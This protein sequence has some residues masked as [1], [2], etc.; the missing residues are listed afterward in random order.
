MNRSRHAIGR[1][2][3]GTCGMVLDRLQDRIRE[4]YRRGRRFSAISMEKYPERP[5][6]YIVFLLSACIQRK[7]SIWPCQPVPG[8]ASRH[9]EDLRD[10]IRQGGHYTYSS[11][12]LGRISQERGGGD[13]HWIIQVDDWI[14]AIPL[15]IH[16]RVVN[17]TMTVGKEEITV[18]VIETEVD[19]EAMEVFFR[20]HAEFWAR[21]IDA[22]MDS[23]HVG[24]ARRLLV[25][26]DARL[27][28]K[29]VAF[30]Q[31]NLD[32]S[33]EDAALAALAP[34]ASLHAGVAALGS[35]LERREGHRQH[36]EEF[37]RLIDVEDLP[38]IEIVE[39]RFLLAN[40]NRLYPA[41]WGNPRQWK[42]AEGAMAKMKAIKPCPPN[43]RG[44]KR[45]SLSP[46][47][48]A[49]PACISLPDT[50]IGGDDRR[51]TFRPGSRRNGVV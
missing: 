51:I 27:G 46:A 29:A 13:T 36:I 17:R 42:Y 18:E 12:G 41:F 50:E 19:Q 31:A 33:E 25:Q 20:L 24:L 28:E 44:Y 3:A 8:R 7:L 21:N 39:R 11:P 34:E 37:N 26:R 2:D 47:P 5:A 15:F 1:P 48:G 35:P 9:G 43:A 45:M 38:R 23:Q 49:S 10:L 22:V 32:A 4:L 6:A 40:R 14:E 16:E 30:R